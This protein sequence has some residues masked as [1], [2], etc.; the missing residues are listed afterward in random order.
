MRQIVVQY[1]QNCPNLSVVL[2]RLS[3]VGVIGSDVLL[4]EV[5][6]DGPTPEGFAGSPTVLIDGMNPLGSMDTQSGVS[7][8]LR[9]PSIKE[10]REV[11]EQH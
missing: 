5:S 1:V 8:T 4:L 9:L 3:E 10:L 2:E 11:L 6:E 7:C